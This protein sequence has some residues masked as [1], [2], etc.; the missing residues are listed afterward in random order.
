MGIK[1]VIPGIDENKSNMHRVLK[2]VQNR[3]F[4]VSTVNIL[5]ISTASS[6]VIFFPK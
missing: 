3:S 4:K 2:I 5:K 6:S 1:T